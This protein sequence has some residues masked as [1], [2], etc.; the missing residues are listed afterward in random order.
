MRN[1]KIK[2]ALVI[3]CAAFMIAT[4]SF[5]SCFTALAAE[6]TGGTTIAGDLTTDWWN[7]FVNEDGSIYT[8][9]EKG[10]EVSKFQNLE[11]NIDWNAAKADGL[12]FVMIRL[13]YG[14]TEDPY[15]YEN[16]KGAQAAGIKVGVYL[17]STAQNLE[18]TKAETE[19]TLKMLKGYSLQYPVAYDVEVNSMLA[20]GAT[21]DDMTAMID[22]YCKAVAASG[23]IPIIYAN[24]TWLTKHMNLSQLPYDVWYA[25][26]PKDK[27]YRP[28]SG[29][30][31]TIWQS[32]EKGTVKGIKGYVTTEFS[33]YT[34]GGNTGATHGNISTMQAGTVQASGASI[35]SGA[36]TAAG[37]GAAGTTAASASS[38]NGIDISENG[39]VKG[40][41]G[42]EQTVIG[43][44]ETPVAESGS[45]S[46]VVPETTGK[47]GWVFENNNY[48][49]YIT[50]IRQYGFVDVDGKTYYLGSDGVM[51]AGWQE[52]NGVKYYF[53]ASGA[54]VKGTTV[55][56][57]GIKNVFDANGVWTGTSN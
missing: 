34:Y 56:I 51:H 26:Y 21:A 47:N 29:A 27:V 42:T 22:Y 38:Q 43:A 2:R 14:T 24:K 32:S 48:S 25:S 41:A 8:Y 9:I 3:G 12:D 23:Y 11:G 5:N 52:I 40:T 37:T 1:N 17:C 19:L 39:P 18:Q 13:A 54:M 7:G 45:V 10:T 16:L 31:T 4:S 20:G 28:V 30:R 6:T 36:V 53:D 46:I 33:V 55:V 57:D 49:Y 44:T 50:G 15:F 35:L